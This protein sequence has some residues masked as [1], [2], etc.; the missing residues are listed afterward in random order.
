VRNGAEG[1]KTEVIIS[2]GKTDKT[3]SADIV[4]KEHSVSVLEVRRGEATLL[5]HSLSRKNAILRT[6]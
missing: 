3:T 5:L 4:K 2:G 1:Q 6:E